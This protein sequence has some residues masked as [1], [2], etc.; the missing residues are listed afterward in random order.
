MEMCD[1]IEEY[2]AGI[3]SGE[4]RLMFQNHMASCPTCRT[5]WEQLV[6]LDRE[7]RKALPRVPKEEAIRTEWLENLVA[8]VRYPN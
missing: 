8:R 6:F 3:L 2:F 4:D 7:L 5:R 1:R